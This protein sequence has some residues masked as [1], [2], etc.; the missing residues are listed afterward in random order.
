MKIRVIG[1]I[2]MFSDMTDMPRYIND[3]ISFADNLITD[4]CDLLILNGDTLDSYKYYSSDI[5]LINAVKVVSYIIEKCIQTDTVFCMLKGTESHDGGIV[6][7]MQESYK[8]YKN[9]KFYSNISYEI[10][11][12]IVFR[13]IPELY[14]GNYED[15]KRDVF[16]RMAD[17]TFF[18]GSVDGVIP[19]IKE[20]DNITNLPLSVL[21]KEEDLIKST[22]LFSA[23]SHIH[24]RINIKDK[25]FYVNS[26]NTNTF[27]DVDDNK[28]FMDFY[29]DQT[30]N[31]F[32]YEYRINPNARKFVKYKFNN[33]EEYTIDD[34]KNR[35][36]FIISERENKV[37]KL[38]IKTN[39]SNDSLYKISLIRQLVEK[40][41][42][43]VDTDIEKKEV[44]IENLSYYTDKSISD[45]DKINKIAKE[46]YDYS[47][48][49]TYLN[50]VLVKG[51]V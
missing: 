30:L 43:K 40:Y 47:F 13:F 27:A 36:S 12:G 46:K 16:S 18:H 22:R 14:Y 10:I 51:M 20:E 48:D 19:Y 28:G 37:I 5:R 21:I 39:D 9:I 6:S 24:K 34:I 32:V 45:I 3:L 31:T 44:V 41:G 17:V 2:H 23:G 26:Y 11:D 35:I 15:F 38:E 25:I 4:P 1:D 42:I 49:E 33:L 7:L 50:D 8:N 29:I